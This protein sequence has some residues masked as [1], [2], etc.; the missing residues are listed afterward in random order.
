MSAFIIV[1]GAIALVAAFAVFLPLFKGGAREQSR[2][3][4]DA[5]V[6]RDQLAELDRDVE[7]GTLSADQAAGS[8]AEI[9]RR[10]LAAS[11]KAERSES[12][13]P[14]PRETSQLFAQIGI[15]ALPVTGLALYLL[16]G[17]P[18][19][20]DA[21]F[22]ARSEAEQRAGLASLPG[23]QV[24][25]S[26]ADAEADFAAHFGAEL[27]VPEVNPEEEALLAQ[28][29]SVL[30]ERPDDVEG[31][32]LL[33]DAHMRRGEH[34][35]AARIYGE[36]A[37]ILGPRAEGALFA[38]RAEA[39]ILA[40][41]GYVS[42][43]AERTLARALELAP[44]HPAA[45]YYGGLALA[46]RG[47]LDR[48]IMLWERLERESPPEAPWMP[49]LGQMLADARQARGGGAFSSEA[50]VPGTAARG[51]SAE[52]LAAAEDLSPEE[53]QEMI[54]GMVAQLE[55]RLVTQGGEPEEW[56][57]LISAHWR[58]GQQ[59]EARR[60]YA[61]SQEALDGGAASFIR[62]QALVLGVITE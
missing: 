5:A 31:R 26:Q 21:P 50:G 12:L 59:R 2:A 11:A 54:R 29:K 36:I 16:I 22:D 25:P 51:P 52:D 60:T 9:G 13:G 14:A 1:A 44:A 37:D 61:L 20:P 49:M 18:G 38:D 46:Q 8:R 42:P 15:A 28:L 40:T 4:R 3:A 6:Y 7:R 58:L 23:Q 33:A 55:E 34:S 45:R 32:R 24:R 10:L 48:A 56:L 41:G 35:D 30:A 19:Q 27:P 53:R 43:E 62:E 57:R 39:L 47:D 17:A